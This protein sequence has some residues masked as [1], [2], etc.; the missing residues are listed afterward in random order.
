[1]LCLIRKSVKSVP[2]PK[3]TPNEG[4]CATPFNDFMQVYTLIYIYCIRAM[5]VH[6]T[7][8]MYTMIKSLNVN[9]HVLEEHEG[10]TV[11]LQVNLFWYKITCINYE[12]SNTQI[13]M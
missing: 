9:V 12:S 13:M 11:L 3:L 6:L 5:Y 1:M 4:N 7:V 10:K 2:A 8:H